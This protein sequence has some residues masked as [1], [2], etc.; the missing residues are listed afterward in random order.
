M[1]LF[2]SIPWSSVLMWIA[3][4]AALMLANEAARANKWVGLSLF[5]V[6]P[7][8]LTI[9][10][11]PTTAGEGSS[12]G[13]WFHWVKVYSALAGCLGFM[14]LRFIPGLIKNKFALMFPAA[15]LALNIFEAVIR[16]FQVYGLDGR[17]DGVMMVGGPWNIMNGV[18]GLLNLLTICGWMGI[19]I[20]RGKQKDMIWPD[21]L[22]F[23]IIA[24]DLWNFAY[25]YNC[26]GD[27][28]FYAGA[29]LLVSCTIPA[30]FIK[31]G[32]WLQHR[33][34]TLAFW[35]MFTMA[36]PAFVGESMF[37]VKSSN[38]PQALFVV[39]AIAL[40]ANIAVVIYQV[41]KIVKGRRN[42][43]TDEIYRDLP[44]YQKVVEANRPLAAEPLEQALAV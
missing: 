39:S 44:A 43:L 40:A 35:M 42:P 18:A 14:A 6:L 29:A 26:V 37:A 28:A 25:V 27:H 5:L 1:F 24:Y 30:F 11:W 15:I 23:W 3:V 7:V 2:E 41:V 13:T 32:A 8:V 33:A 38:D 16:D 10:V 36:F 4:V 21:M 19:F 34:Q 17:I 20:S 31:R 9:F 22:W 12:T